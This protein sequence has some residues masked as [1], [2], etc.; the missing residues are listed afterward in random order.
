MIEIHHVN[1]TQLRSAYDQLYDQRPIRHQ[2]S[3]YQWVFKIL[4]VEP[5]NRYLDVACGQARLVELAA[6][7][8][9]QA[10]GTDYSFSALAA[11]TNHHPLFVANGEY[12]PL[13]SGSID[14][15]SNIG[16]LEHYSDPLKGAREMARVLKPGGLACI[17]VPNT[18]SIMATVLYAFHTG[19]IID[20]GQP[21]QRYCTRRG[22]ERLLQENGFTI[23]AVKKYER[24]WPLNRKDFLSYLRR[25][26]ELL[27]LS[28]SPFVPLNLANSFAF[29][30]KQNEG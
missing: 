3:F 23:L 30:C 1:G 4:R 20:D 15:L 11:S 19:E 10:F 18:F 9:M 28:I 24:E 12:L 22:W 17:F 8:G 6:E 14:R 27:H 5:G 2:D 13:Q 7:Q 29:I 25:P 21:I 16:S 26:K